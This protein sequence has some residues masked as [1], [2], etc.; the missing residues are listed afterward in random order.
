MMSNEILR[1]I[2]L[3]GESYRLTQKKKKKKKKARG[4]EIE[5][6]ERFPGSTVERT[7]R[8]KQ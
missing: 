4:L 8:S 5:G 3:H 6:N 7:R 2:L 1:A